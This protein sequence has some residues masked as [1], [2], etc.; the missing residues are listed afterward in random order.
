[1]LGQ[2]IGD[3]LPSAV[4]VAL[5]PIPVVAVVLVLGTPKARTAG[6]TFATGWVVGLAALSTVVV[7]VL[8]SGVDPDT[9]TGIE[10]FKVGV[11][12]LFLLMAARQWTKRPQDGDAVEMPKWIESVDSITVPRAMALG[13]ALSGANPKNVALTLAGRLDLRGRA[14]PGGY[15]ADARRL[16]GIGID[17]RRRVGAL[18]PLDPIAGGPTTGGNRAVHV[19][20]RRGDHVRRTAVA[21][22]EAARR[23]PRQDLTPIDHWLAPHQG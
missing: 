7:L 3:L 11:G 10:W 20:Q 16:R 6:P 4:A 13:A 5:S 18:L 12:A 15:G 1:M 19:R 9:E 22:R 17:H 23:R 8:G 21:G 2:A 14:G